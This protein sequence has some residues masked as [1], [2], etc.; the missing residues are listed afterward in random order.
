MQYCDDFSGVTSTPSPVT[1]TVN[2][3]LFTGL[4]SL[5]VTVKDPQDNEDTIS[6]LFESATCENGACPGSA[7]CQ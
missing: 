1:Q 2:C 4:E 6:A 5:S 3:D 7:G